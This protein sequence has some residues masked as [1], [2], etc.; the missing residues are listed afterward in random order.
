MHPHRPE[1]P[2]HP[3]SGGSTECVIDERMASATVEGGTTWYMDPSP[4][5]KEPQCRSIL[6]S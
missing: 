4:L 3:Q 1:R 6:F 5:D 2:I